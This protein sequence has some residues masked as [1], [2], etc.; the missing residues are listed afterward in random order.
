MALK[1]W[2]NRESVIKTLTS[3]RLQVERAERE[4]GHQREEENRQAILWHIYKAQKC[5]KEAAA[6]LVERQPI[7]NLSSSLRGKA[8][9]I[10][11]VE[12]PKVEQSGTFDSHEASASRND[13]LYGNEQS[14]QSEH[15]PERGAVDCP[16]KAERVPLSYRE[17]PT[18]F[19]GR[20][21]TRYEFVPTF[22]INEMHRAFDKWLENTKAL[23]KIC[24]NPEPLKDIL[25]TQIQ[26]GYSEYIQIQETTE[27]R[28]AFDK[29]L[30][31]TKALIKM[32]DNP[33][34]LKGILAT[35]I[36]LKYDLQGIMK[37]VDKIREE[38]Q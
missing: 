36:Q 3:A 18:T 9:A 33:E 29:W 8:E 13:A 25:N 22:R 35:Q 19:R 15:A 16:S 5:L 1:Y 34:P 20:E 32:C 2:E 23:I 6:L 38:N 17:V 37:S 14:P 27:T 31:E 30:E 26:F 28:E 21:T 24:D 10:N 11:D 7:E 12:P 4:F